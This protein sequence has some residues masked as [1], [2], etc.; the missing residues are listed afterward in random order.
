MPRSRRSLLA[1]LAAS[2]LAPAALAPACTCATPS[3]ELDGGDLL[4]VFTHDGGSD[5]GVDAG[6]RRGKHLRDA[7]LADARAAEPPSPA[8]SV[9]APVAGNCVASEGQPDRDIRRTLGRPPCRGAQV[10]EWKDADGSPRYACVVAPPGVETRAPLPLIVFFHD[11]GDDPSAVDKKTA[12][13]KSGAAYGL[14]GDPAHT[15]FIVLAPQGRHIRGGKHGSVFDTDYTGADNQDVAAVDHFI[16]ELDA[17]GLVDHRRT[18]TLGASYGGHMAATYAMMR[19][20]KVAAF[21]A[22]ATDAPR[23]SWSC[24]GPPPPGLM[25]YRACDG[26]FSC[27]SVERW[28]RARDAQQAETAWLRLGAAN[29]EEPSCATRNKCTPRGA[30]GNHHRWPKGREGDVLAF[31]KRHVLG[32]TSPAEEPPKPEEPPP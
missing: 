12:L 26:F 24:G 17:K 23:A 14:A 19:A 7:G 15:G 6:H 32:A 16:A 31:F 9:R 5:G 25:I 20:D 22:F 1:F 18:Y 3:S 27:E 30:E 4:G 13:R 28:L 2:L 29:D 8:A 21:A 11:E 10:L